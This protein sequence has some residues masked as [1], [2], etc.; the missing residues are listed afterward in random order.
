MLAEVISA[1]G[2]AAMVGMTDHAELQRRVGQQL[3]GPFEDAML[4]A[5]HYREVYAFQEYLGERARLVIPVL[6]LIGVTG[7]ACGMAPIVALVGTSAGS[8]LGGLLL[9][10]LMLIGSVFVLGLVFFSWLEERSLARTLGRRTAREGRAMR[11]MRKK[12]G[13]DLGRAPRVPWL[14]AA[15][16]LALPF[17]MLLSVAPEIGAILLALLAA[18]PFAFARLDR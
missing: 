7:V 8:A 1:A 12:L 14:F 9:M 13:V 3:L 10:P 2:G 11:W 6:V 5:R 4:L 18:A 16:F 17:A 15:L